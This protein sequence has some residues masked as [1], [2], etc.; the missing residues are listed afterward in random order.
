VHS[1]P[2][3]PMYGLQK[4][5]K[6]KIVEDKDTVESQKKQLKGLSSVTARKCMI[7]K[8]CQEFRR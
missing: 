6:N 4:V 1:H 3:A 5:S 7:W 8:F 2:M